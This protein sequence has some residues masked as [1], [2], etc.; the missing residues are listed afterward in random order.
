M[1][2]SLVTRRVLFLGSD[3]F[4]LACLKAVLPISETVSVICPAHELP[5]AEFSKAQGLQTFVPEHSHVR[6]KDWAVLQAPE[7]V[8]PYDFIISS[9]FGHLIPQALINRSAH[10]INVHPSLLPRH[11]GAS[12]I[13]YT[14]YSRDSVTG[15]SLISLSSSYDKG[16][17]YTQDTLRTVD[18]SQETY[19]SLYAKLSDLAG[20]M[21]PG[22]LIDFQK[23]K[24]QAARQDETLVTLAPK[25]AYDFGRLSFEASAEEGF[26]KFR[27]LKGFSNTY[28]YFQGKKVLPLA[29]RRST[30]DEL[31]RLAKY[32]IATPGS[33]WLLYPGIGCEVSKKFSKTVGSS[34]YVKFSDGWLVLENMQFEGKPKSPTTMKEFINAYFDASRYL[35]QDFEGLHSPMLT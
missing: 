32:S 11:R 25:I 29:F 13:Q 2:S 7:L 28:C 19:E 20:Q 3:S 26:A 9:S 17:I 16:L 10:S 18:L 21:L 1:A 31:S 23:F 27:A 12:P 8:Q 33:L 6:M 4:S 15:V 34:I 30:A 22:L 35:A 5:L 14:L 24:S